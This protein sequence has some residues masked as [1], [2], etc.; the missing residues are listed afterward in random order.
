MCVWWDTLK[1]YR[2]D[3]QGNYLDEDGHRYTSKTQDVRHKSQLH[4]VCDFIT[5]QARV[6][7]AD[8]ERELKLKQQREEEERQRK[9]KEAEKKRA[10]EEKKAEKKRAREEKKAEKRRAK[11]EKE[12]EKKRAKEEK[13]AEKKRAKKDV[14]RDTAA[15]GDDASAAPEQEEKEEDK[16][17]GEK[18]KEEEENEKEE[19]EAEKQEAKEDAEGDA[20]EEDKE[21]QAREENPTLENKEGNND[22]QA[23]EESNDNSLRNQEADDGVKEGPSRLPEPPADFMTQ[24]RSEFHALNVLVQVLHNRISALDELN[25]CTTTLS[26]LLPGEEPRPGFISSTAIERQANMALE[27]Q[28]RQKLARMRG[29]LMYLKTIGQETACPI[30]QDEMDGMKS[31]WLC[32]HCFCLGCTQSM[33]ANKRKVDCPLC[34][35]PSQKGTLEVV[36]TQQQQHALEKSF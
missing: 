16:E 31:V 29:R 33:F 9:E 18:D 6:Y 22:E 2:M 20:A 4:I 27:C 35:T 26:L 24:L 3:E 36:N 10:K 13:E 5:A 21:E 30:C 11:E 25:T 1:R 23:K 32:G 7:R 12:A 34:R 28:A 14:E 8:V 19:N 15:D 17:E